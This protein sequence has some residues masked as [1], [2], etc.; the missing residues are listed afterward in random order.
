MSGSTGPIMIVAGGTGGHVFPGLAVAEA[1]RA[2]HGS[3]VVWLGTQR[4]IEARV[5]PPLGIDVEWI[6]ITG[7]R[8]KGVLAW[9]GAPF[10]V[11]SAVLQALGALRRRRPAAVLG[12]G[13][14][15]AGPGGVAAWLA[16]KP[17]LLHEQNAV[18]GTTNR[19]LAPLA[20]RIFTAYPDTFPPS[21]RV[22]VIGNPVRG[23]IAPTDAPRE[24]LDARRGARRR[25]LVVGGSQ[26]ARVLNR[27]LPLALAQLPPAERPE[28]WHQAGRATIDEARAAYADAGVD[29]RIDV[30]I[31]DMPSAYR[32]ADLVVARAGGSTL[33]ELEIVGVGAVLVP[34]ATAIDDHQTANARHFTARGAGVAIPERELDAAALARTLTPLLRDMDR[35]IAMAEAA[36]AQAH[37]HAAERLAAACLTAAEGRV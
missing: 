23:S 34:L 3:S 36:R 7:L 24:R 25:L 28:V 8:G 26:G 27:T 37:A 13:G 6:S 22:E 16:R 20:A 11:V 31:D 15:V 32:W 1:L 10:R 29:A 17:L 5:V 9:L 33:A 4:G 30:F 21:E 18:A 19:L 2:R 35:L 12:M 14:F